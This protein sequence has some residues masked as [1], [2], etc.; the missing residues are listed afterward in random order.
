M[1]KFFEQR[2]LVAKG[3]TC[4]KTRR[5]AERSKFINAL[6][7]GT[8]VRIIILLGIIATLAML[9]FVAQE[10]SRWTR[11]FTTIFLLIAGI[12]ELYLNDPEIEKSN[13]RLLLTFGIIL[14]QQ[15]VF[16]IIFL[17]ASTGAIDESTGILLLPYIFA[18]LTLSILLGKNGGLFATIFGTLLSTVIFKNF[19]LAH[20]IISLTTGFIAVITT[21]RVRRRS[22]IIRAGIYAG[23]GTWIIGILL[24]LIG[25][26]DWTSFQDS[27]CSL[28][29]F[30]S[31][32]AVSVGI[33]T[34]VIVSGLLPILENLFRVTTDIS[35]LEMADLNHPLLRRLS[36]EAPGTYQHSMAMASLAESAAEAI[37]ANPTICRVGAYFHDIGKL[38]KPEYFIENI[39]STE[40]PHDDL[41]PTMSALIISA[42]IKEGINL[43]LQNKLHPRVLDIIRQHHGTTM[44][45][46]FFQKARQQQEDARLGGKIMNIR[47]EDIPAVDSDSFRYPGPKPQTKEAAIVG[48]ADAAESASRS[49]E[50]P[51]PQRIGDL[52]HT[53]LEE[54]LN[55]GQYDECPIMMNELH[56][57]AGSLVSNLTSMLHSR[58]AYK[59][60]SEQKEEFAT[61][62]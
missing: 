32:L 37:G 23:V 51:T 12:T 41:T 15:L 14:V 44:V 60:R 62:Q 6:E 7:S 50:R 49:M 36:L 40:N 19:V 25:P 20:M 8:L 52:V 17:K 42:H 4:G 56:K 38:L 31:A 35:W 22:R 18:P 10:P 39:S 30:Q 28:V 29:F 43:A 48:L 33:G 26:I 11:F 34:A 45:G 55:D 57:I 21:R 24:E 5:R 3:L 27:Y 13:S 61:N 9:I 59:K 46:F 47:P 53:I 58:I 54:R 16:K 2:Q 1:V